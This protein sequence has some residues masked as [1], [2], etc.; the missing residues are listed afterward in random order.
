MKIFLT[1][2]PGSGKSTVLLKAINLLKQKGLK[3]GGI[4]TPE[5]RKKG[6]RIGFLVKD[7]YSNEQ[8]ILASVDLKSG[9]RLGK[10]R[11][12]LEEFEKIALKA[13]DFAFENCDLTAID[14]LGKMEFFSTRFKEKVLEILN[15]NK[16]V[17]A[18]L[19]RNFVKQFK[20]FGKI[21]EVTPENREKLAE[22]IVKYF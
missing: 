20:D 3:V 13:L 8:G 2:K 15:S 17:I 22:E 16:K 6:K 10:Y 18:C 12:N 19:H 11:I 5:V 14:E 7:I 9:P 1:G 4:I 21:F